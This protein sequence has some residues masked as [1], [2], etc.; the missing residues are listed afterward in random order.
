MKWSDCKLNFKACLA[1]TKLWS[2][3][4]A[5]FYSRI[6]EL[7]SHLS[8]VEQFDQALLKFCQW[9]ENMLSNLHSSPQI[10]IGKLQPAAT[11][12][13]VRTEMFFLHLHP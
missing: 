2:Y 11:Q 8:L 7:Q 1:L 4:G 5:F 10:N 12:V 9:S 13:K 6:S 3:H